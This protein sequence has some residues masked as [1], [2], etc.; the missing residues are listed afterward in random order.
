M[1]LFT[2]ALFA[3]AVAS[4]RVAA[5][6]QILDALNIANYVLQNPEV[7]CPTIQSLIIHKTTRRVTRTFRVP[8]LQRCYYVIDMDRGSKFLA[9]S[10]FSDSA[11]PQFRDDIFA[12][13]KMGYRIG[14]FKVPI[15]LPYQGNYF[16]VVKEQTDLQDPVLRLREVGSLKGCNSLVDHLSD[17][18]ENQFRSAAKKGISSTFDARFMWVDSKWKNISFLGFNKPR[19]MKSVTASTVAKVANEAKAAARKQYREICRASH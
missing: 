5:L 18:V 9:W 2:P 8:D 3:F 12:W 7:P 1:R 16:L 13:T 14:H 11:G 15:G 10:E 6:P 17:L 4:S 19:A